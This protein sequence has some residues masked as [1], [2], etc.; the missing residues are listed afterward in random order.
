[1]IKEK[2]HEEMDS[3]FAMWE[4]MSDEQQRIFDDMFDKEDKIW[5]EIEEYRK[6]GRIHPAEIEE[7][8]KILSWRYNVRNTGSDIT[9][10]DLI[11][12]E[13]YAKDVLKR[14]GVKY[15]SVHV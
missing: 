2:Y 5:V 15:E 3:V 14:A 4:N 8:K 7:A 10:E 11:E 1:M 6:Q 9:R 12:M 13:A